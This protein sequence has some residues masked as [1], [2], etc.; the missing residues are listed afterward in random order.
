MIDLLEL[1]KKFVD[2]AFGKKKPHYE[3]TL[4]WLLQ[5]KPDA[6]LALQIAAYSHDI[7]RAFN[8]IKKDRTYLIYSDPNDL[9]KHQIEG[10][11][12]M[13]EFILKNTANKDLANKV[14]DLISKHET[15]GNDEQNIL[16]DADSIS[17]LEINA[18]RHVELLGEIPYS[19]IIEKFNWMYNRISTKKG[20]ETAQPI[21][22]KA[23]S[24]LEAKQRLV[25][26]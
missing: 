11:N 9:I 23:L 14:K 5:I 4:Y 22:E 17:Y 12:I 15:G 26:K 10:G 3:R 18:P 16:K 8:K 7:E 6:D 24:L 1:T 21:Y 19:E 25:K 2:E 13:R 20:K